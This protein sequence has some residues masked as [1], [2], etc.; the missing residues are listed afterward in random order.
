MLEA[1]VVNML[2]RFEEI[3]LTLWQRGKTNIVLI[4]SSV[5]DRLKIIVS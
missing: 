2:A 4:N 3:E 5:N 1:Y